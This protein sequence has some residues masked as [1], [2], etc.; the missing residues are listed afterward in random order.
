MMNVL[1][2]CVGRRN[3]LVEFF[4]QAL[5]SRG[6]VYGADADR[7]ACALQECDKAFVVRRVHETGYCDEILGALPGA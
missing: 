4:R 1:L 2:T 3:Y 5:G 7:Y 6:N